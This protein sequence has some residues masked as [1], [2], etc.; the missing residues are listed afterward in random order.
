MCAAAALA[1]FHFI[2]YVIKLVKYS[3]CCFTHSHSGKP[4]FHRVD[5]Y[6]IRQL[7]FIICI[8]VKPGDL[9]LCLF[10]LRKTIFAAHN[11]FIL[12]GPQQIIFLF[13]F[14]LPS[15]FVFVKQGR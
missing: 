1:L 2:F 5:I 4:P 13:C 8:K 6:L 7:F 12:L 3:G 15:Q 14:V 10:P 11:V 9:A